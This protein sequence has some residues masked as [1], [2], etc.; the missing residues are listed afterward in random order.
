MIHK[1]APVKAVNL[2]TLFGG[3]LICSTAILGVIFGV[4]GAYCAINAVLFAVN[5]SRPSNLLSALV[6]NHS[7]MSGD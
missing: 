5:P 7:Q 4:F 3:F 1:V 2:N 6:P